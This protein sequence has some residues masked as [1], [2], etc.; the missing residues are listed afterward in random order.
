[1]SIFTKSQHVH[2]KLLK[3]LYL[4]PSWFQMSIYHILLKLGPGTK[5][6]SGPNLSIDQSC[7]EKLWMPKLLEIWTT[8]DFGCALVPCLKAPYC[9][10][11]SSFSLNSGHLFFWK[12]TN[13]QGKRLHWAIAL[14]M[15]N[16]KIC[17]VFIIF[18]FCCCIRFFWYF[19]ICIGNI[20]II[21]RQSK[22]RFFR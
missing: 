18:L 15:G 4:E 22:N 8:I 19:V 21:V 17:F 10:K 12:N 3:C 13:V 7:S 1:M 6:S 9:Y 16:Y 20:Q 14:K 2:T 5:D 11:I